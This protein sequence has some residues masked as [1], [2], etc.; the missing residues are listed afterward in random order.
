LETWPFTLELRRIVGHLDRA[1]KRGDSMSV[2]IEGISVVVREATV[3]QKYK[4]GLGQYARDCP[5]NTLCVDEHLARVGFLAP[6]DVQHYVQTLEKH[7]FV[8]ATDDEFADIAIVDQIHGL[9]KKCRWLQFFRHPDGYSFCWQTGT[10]P[11]KLSVPVGW[12]LENSLSKQ[13]QFVPTEQ[14]FQKLQFLRHEKGLDVFLDKETGEIVYMGR[15][16]GQAHELTSDAYLEK[17]A[18]LVNPYIILVDVPPRSPF[19]AQG[20]QDI[21]QGIDYLQQAI[22]LYPGN[23]RAYWY[24]GK[25][26]QAIQASGRA[27]Q[28]FRLA[29][30]TNPNEP[31]ICREL[32]KE[33]LDQGK[34]QEG[35]STALAAVRLRPKD[36]GLLANLGLAL[37]LNAQLREAEKVTKEAMKIDPNDR[38][39][40]S[41]L[42]VISEVRSGQRPQPHR[43]SDLQSG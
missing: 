17:G 16:F 9:T 4:G 28:N 33:C 35:V 40:Q 21:A 38:I 11:G 29:Y 36:S 13:F 19:S 8:F 15:P 3:A 42:R 22:E 6:D 26:F 10:E 39:T 1:R 31:D 20:Q 14:V 12:R 43:Y 25:T 2:L 5:N 30:E 18:E 23:W 34:T 41:I 7:N 27:Y 32:M 37:L 24:L